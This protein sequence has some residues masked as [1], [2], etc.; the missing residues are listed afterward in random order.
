[1]DIPAEATRE[2]CE[3]A[4]R[5]AGASMSPPHCYYP[6]AFFERLAVEHRRVCRVFDQQVPGYLNSRFR[7]NALL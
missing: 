5:F 6:R 3:V 4:R 7:F 1:M 2:E